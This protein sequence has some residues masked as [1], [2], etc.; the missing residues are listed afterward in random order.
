VVAAAAK[1][2]MV[3]PVVKRAYIVSPLVN[4]PSYLCCGS[5]FA[6]LCMTGLTYIVLPCECIW[7]MVLLVKILET[8]GLQ[9]A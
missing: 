8:Q 3:K 6:E 2:S 9:L 1:A 7:I 4:S 5:T